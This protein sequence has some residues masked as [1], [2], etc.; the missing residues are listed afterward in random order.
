MKNFRSWF[1]KKSLVFKTVALHAVFFFIAISFFVIYSLSVVS[2]VIDEASSDLSENEK[3]DFMTKFMPA[4]VSFIVVGIV[5][6]I[7]AM[8]LTW[9]FVKLFQNRVTKLVSEVDAI[10]NDELSGIEPTDSVDEIGRLTNSISK[11]SVKMN[12][13]VE[14]AK[15]A[16]SVK[17]NF[18]ARMSHDIRTP[19]NAIN[20][21]IEIIK[22]NMDDK[23]RVE[24]CIRKIEISSDHLLAIIDE[25][26]D[27]S[28]LEDGNFEFT[29]DCFNINELIDRC[30]DEATIQAASD[31]IS[32]EVDKSELSNIKVIG[33]DMYTRR[34]FANILSNAIK[35][36][37]EGGKIFVN[38]T[39]NF[40][41]KKRIIYKFVV[42]DTGVGMTPEFIKRAFD[43]FTQEGNEARTSYTGTGLGLSITRKL[44]DAMGGRI[45]IESELNVGST[46]T[47]TIPFAVNDSKA[48][49]EEIRANES[50]AEIG[51]SR[52]LLVEDNALNLE[53]AKYML[54][55]KGVKVDTAHNGNVAVEM[56]KKSDPFAYDII[57]MD[58]MMPEK[59]GIEATKEIR[60]LQRADAI[61][62]PIVALSANAYAED[63]V[64]VKE[65]GMNDHLAKPI[66]V[67]RLNDIL[68]KYKKMYDAKKTS[69]PY[70]QLF[71]GK[72]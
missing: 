65:A 10:A 9:L 32:I 4:L 55:D 7:I 57:F 66:D 34:V 39:E 40:L 45:E 43:L 71:V 37:K 38:V 6:F 12:E 1:E 64:A 24:D 44:L 41:D 3:A 42:K 5:L 61:L 27:M 60:K 70:S 72:K 21:M 14:E 36:N 16:Y 53:I 68:V 59:N 13:R 2:R 69:H 28:K 67:N 35:F 51:G 26:L 54:E 17:T 23:E 29:N 22:D 47:F 19:M 50:T 56:F 25:I 11:M 18:L 20:G 15:C 30:I 33:S 62:V 48:T 8:L 31:N 58:V 46:V 49:Q 63:V 52:A